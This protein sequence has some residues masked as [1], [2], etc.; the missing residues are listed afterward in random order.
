M[1]GNLSE[2]A[3]SSLSL[4]LSLSVSLTDSSMLSQRLIQLETELAGFGWLA[5]WL[6]L[7]FS[8]SH[9]LKHAETEIETA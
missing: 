3:H 2:A 9:R 8:F 6:L 4:S 1:K 7:S 5:G